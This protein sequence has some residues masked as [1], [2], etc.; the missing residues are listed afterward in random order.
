MIT[1]LNILTIIDF[2][3]RL[4][5]LLV[6]LPIGILLLAACFYYMS[7]RQRYR[8]LRPAVP[9]SLLLGAAAAVLSCISGLLLKNSGG[10]E[11][12]LVS[13]HQWLGIGLTVFAG[14]T[15]RISLVKPAHLKWMMPLLIILLIITGH[16][17]GTLTHGEGYLTK[18]PA[19]SNGADA[20][21]KSIPDVQ[22][23]IVY[24]DIVKPILEARCYNC[25]G[26][27][28]QKGQLRLDEP[29][30]IQ[31]GGKSG[32]TLVPG[33]AGESEIIKRILLAADNED[34]MPPKEKPQL[35]K[36]QTELLAW[37][38]NT[39]ANFHKKT[40]ELEQPATIKPYLAALQSGGTA[41]AASATGIPARET[42]KAPDSLLQKLRSMDVAVHAVSQNSNYLAVNFVAVSAVTPEHVRLIGKLNRQIVWLKLGGKN[43][44][45][46]IMQAA[47]Q[48]TMLTKLWL[49]YSAVTSRGLAYLKNCSA[50]EYLNLSGTAVTAED[51]QQLGGLK[52]LKRLY[53]YQ[54]PV[55]P[56][57]FAA[58]QKT[59]PAAIIDTGGYQLESL[60]TD[61][62]IVKQP[63]V[64]N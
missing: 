42:E 34:H 18:S 20:A 3:G 47:G 23:A 10:Y 33:S 43:I 17:G 1:L 46:S 48:L 44:S 61:T 8:M 60:P 7:G 35:T 27:A 57:G 39:G 29:A 51:L 52:N 22:Q 54:T 5:P 53:L 11:T 38:V 31:Q 15:Y 12:A 16:F 26:A 25:H 59:F 9:W 6:H 62:M 2:T 28:K 36:E 13:K 50:L 64:K 32:H 56:G 14:I 58:L 37:W 63:P 55:T 40:A 45:G 30:F 41:V 4:H 24:N 19:K 21:I 49:D